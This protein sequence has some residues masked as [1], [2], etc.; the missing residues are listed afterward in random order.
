[1]IY[2]DR[3]VAGMA[4][5]IIGIFFLGALQLLFIGFLGEYILSINQKVMK[6]PLVIE[7]KRINFK[8]DKYS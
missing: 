4:P 7:E 2:W 8:E 5:I 3:F 6:R 1:M